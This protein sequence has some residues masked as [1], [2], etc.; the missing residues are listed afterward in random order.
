V[1]QR[2]KELHSEDRVEQ[3]QRKMQRLKEWR[4]KM[5][6]GVSEVSTWLKQAKEEPTPVLVWDGVESRTRQEATSFVKA[7]WR[8]VWESKTPE[9]RKAQQERSIKA[10]AGEYLRR[11]QQMEWESPDEDETLTALGK[12]NGAAGADGWTGEEVRCLPADAKRRFHKLAR[13]WEKAGKPPRAMKEFRQVNLV[14]PGKAKEGKLKAEHTRPI[15]VASIWWRAWATAWVTGRKVMEWREK[16]LPKEVIGGKGSKGAEEAGADLLDAL[17]QYG[18]LGTLDYSLCYDHMD[19]EVTVAI[20]EQLGWPSGLTEVLREV[21][22]DQKRWIIWDGHVDPEPL[23]GGTAT[24]QGDPWGPFALNMWMAAGHWIVEEREKEKASQQERATWEQVGRRKSKIYMDDRTWV[25]RTAVGLVSGVHSWKEWSESVGLKE[26]PTKI[27]MIAKSAKLKTELLEVAGDLREFVKDDAEIL[28]L[29]TAGTRGRKTQ[30]KE[31]K[32]LDAAK[33]SLARLR[34]LPVSRAKKLSYCRI[35]GV[36][37][38]TYGWMGR[39]PTKQEMQAVTNA[40]WKSAGGLQAAAPQLRN[41]LEGGT[42]NLEVVLG[43]RQLGMAWRRICREG[44]AD[45]VWWNRTRGTLAR[46]CRDWMAANGWEE[47]GPWK[48]K[49]AKLSLSIDL[50]RE[51]RKELMHKLRESWRAAQWDIFVSRERRD[52]KEMQGIQ[53]DGMA[54]KNARQAAKTPE[55]KAMAMGAFMSPATMQHDR[56][57]QANFTMKCCWCQRVLGTHEHIFWQC[58]QRPEK[59]RKPRDARLARLGWAV[60]GQRDERIVEY[61]SRV[62]REVWKQRYGARERQEDGE[63]QSEEESESAAAATDE[64]STAESVDVEVEESEGGVSSN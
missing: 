59:W 37:Q 39:R 14:K 15:S 13:R 40:I 21:W 10:I 20:M 6:S 22:C 27:Q 4:L 31:K 23:Q 64:E 8:K 48:W 41:V 28:G 61:M 43:Q 11:Q 3:E 33:A 1:E 25:D 17:H 57:A 63:S 47:A 34:V 42:L 19:P 51:N 12:A 45:D 53:Y 55:R 46:V 5:R 56:A 7:H 18:F 2:L 32:R 49:H 35:F 29:V 24:P 58:P 9:E 54:A 44:N 60:E 30:E 16:H 52:S 36:S 62:V 38:G 26:N 50:H